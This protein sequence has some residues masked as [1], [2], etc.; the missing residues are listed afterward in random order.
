MELFSTFL[1][2]YRV[3]RS[4]Q[5][6][7]ESKHGG[8]LLSIIDDLYL[9]KPLTTITN[10]NTTRACRDQRKMSVSAG[11]PPALRIGAIV[12]LVKDFYHFEAIEE[13]S[14]KQFPSYDDRNFYFRGTRENPRSTPS[15]SANKSQGEY[16]LKLG[17]PLFY[18]LNVMKGINAMLNHLHSNEF[19]RCIR[20][21]VSREGTDVMEI[22]RKK[23]LEYQSD[24]KLPNAA[25]E[26]E[27]NFYM[28]V[29]TFIPGEC[30][31]EVEKSHLTPRLLYDVGHC[32]GNADAILQVSNSFLE[33]EGGEGRQRE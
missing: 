9:L 24:L 4:E 8:R 25:K 23:L 11:R 33:R 5:T 31:D 32:V 13:Q 20:P 3:L 29:V 6:A 19:S 21:L 12:K 30:L 15:N 1:N 16:V 10:L 26:A 28:R 2:G 17:N 18:S 22:S 7:V 27:S 14:V